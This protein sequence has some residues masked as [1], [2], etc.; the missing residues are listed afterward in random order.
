MVLSY[1]NF[2]KNGPNDTTLPYTSYE[3]FSRIFGRLKINAIQFSLFSLWHM[4]NSFR[5]TFLSQSQGEKG[6]VKSKAGF[7]LF[8]LSSLLPFVAKNQGISLQ[9]F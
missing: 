2:N 4:I 5:R 6:K 3:M 1:N 8:L 9:D 7:I